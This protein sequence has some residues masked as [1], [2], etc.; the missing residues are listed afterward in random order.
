MV[1]AFKHPT[2]I[3]DKTGRVQQ[4][5]Q[6]CRHLDIIN[7]ALR[8]PRG[9]LLTNRIYAHAVS[10]FKEQTVT[11]WVINFVIARTQIMRH[12]A[13]DFRQTVQIINGFLIA[14]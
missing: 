7:G 9:N 6:Q 8:L 5:R 2:G 1:E 13:F 3:A 14:A 10:T 11:T 12:P 4:R